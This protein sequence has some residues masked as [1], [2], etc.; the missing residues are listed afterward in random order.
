MGQRLLD[1]ARA[2]EPWAL[3]ALGSIYGMGMCY[4][5]TGVNVATVDGAYGWLPAVKD[6]DAEGLLLKRRAAEAGFAP[7]SFTLALDKSHTAAEAPAHVQAA[8]AG[9]LPPKHRTRAQKL[10]GELLERVEA[11]IE[12]QLAVR[13][14]LAE[15]GDSASAAWIGDCYRRGNGV[16]KD[17]AEARRWYERAGGEVSALRELGKLWEKGQGGPKDLDRARALYEEAAELGADPWCRKRLAEK[18][19]LTWYMTR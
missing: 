1:R 15:A 7:A 16:P 17:L 18:F 2:G 8:L 5:D 9:E 11:P 10:V 6:P 13:R 3:L 12:E 4:A 19:G 14:N